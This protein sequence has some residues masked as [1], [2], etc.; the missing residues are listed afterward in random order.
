MLKNLF[1]ISLRLFQREK[2]YAAINIFGLTIGITCSAFLFLYI[3]DE[4]SYDRYHKNA[5]NIYRIITHAI[6][7]D[8]EYRRPSTPVP[9][10]VELRESFPEVINAV[11]FFTTGRELFKHDDRSFYEEDVYY[12]DSTVFEMFTFE[13]IAGDP[14]TALDH[15][16]SMVMSESMAIK[17][18]GSTDALGK[19][20]AFIDREESY[21]VTG[22]MKDVPD[23]SHFHFDALLSLNSLRMF[24]EITNWG[25]LVVITYIQFPEGYNPSDFK[26]KLGKLVAEHV[27][28]LFEKRN[29][30]VDFELQRITDIHLHSKIED[31]DEAGGDISFIY[32]LSVIALFIIT[33]AC[34]NYMNLATAR[35]ARRA[36]EVGVRK[37]LG[38]GRAQLVMQFMAEAFLLAIISLVISM[39]A[40]YLL[41][42]AFNYVSNKDLS[43]MSLFDERVGLSLLFVLVFIGIVG[44]SY[45]AFYLSRF[46]P[47]QV[48]KAKVATV[49]G[50]ALIRKGLVVVQF[51]I[52]I[53]M[54]I[55]TVVV[56]D[57]LRFLMNKD[58]GFDKEEVIRIAIDDPD[59]RRSLVAIED[60]LRHDAAVIKIGTA[61]ATPGENVRK[62]I[63]QVQ[64]NDGKMTERG[65][66]WFSADYDFIDVMGM[67]IVKGRNFDR[68]ILSDTM[69]SILVNE[70]M[71]RRMN[72]SEPLGKQFQGSGAPRT[73]IGVIKDYHQNSLYNEIE[74]LAVLFR[75]NNYYT[76][77]KFSAGQTR[78]L[79]ERI[80]GVWREVFPDKPFE[81]QFLDE[82]FDAQYDAD[83]R[84]ISLFAIF[85]GLTIAIACLGL[86]ALTSFTTEQRTKEI[87]IRKVVGASTSSIVML[88]SKEF[89]P[90]ITFAALLAFPAVYYFMDNW[91]QGFA[92]RI[93]LKDKTWTFVLSATLALVIAMVTVGYQSAKAAWVNPVNALRNE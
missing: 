34:I 55:S 60:R 3:I 85:T 17:Y 16:F 66:D 44:G 4:L 75:K 74:P 8:G 81:Y 10:G 26:P 32:I 21:K 22:I 12:V 29:I 30:K 93:V 73:V 28:P 40:I 92:Y 11:R 6:E 64:D 7:P 89:I 63:A 68:D 54:L 71:V 45:P 67:S 35:S 76:Y 83:E 88:V 27:T 90:L 42:P 84:R 80:E 13:F 38:S 61:S 2:Q 51:S 79:L 78:E 91:L 53:F 31:E 72:W 23:N 65:V 56:Y 33:I 47:A 86:L 70:A 52:S 41:M 18:F 36:K 46:N 9:L 77:I 20:I 37:V 50:N 5:G 14:E 48:L 82:A 39:F 43:F 57:Q 1:K 49:S 25:R 58:L 19:S 62:A 59:M 69:M 15:P 87:G 24:K